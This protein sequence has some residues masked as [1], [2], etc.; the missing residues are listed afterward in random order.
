MTKTLLA[1]ATALVLRVAGLAAAQAQT[2][3][4]VEQPELSES[5]ARSIA[6]DAGLNNISTMTKDRHDAWHGT[7]QAGPKVMPFTITPD[8]KLT[9][10]K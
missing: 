9:K 3:P 10:G 8:A 6:M 2:T 5:Q 1:G 7:A 4:A